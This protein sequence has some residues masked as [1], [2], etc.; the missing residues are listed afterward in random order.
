M[1]LG[2]LPASFCIQYPIDTMFA[3]VNG[4]PS[5][6]RIASDQAFSFSPVGV[7]FSAVACRVS[8]PESTDWL[9]VVEGAV[10]GVC[11]GVAVLC[12]GFC[13]ALWLGDGIFAVAKPSGLALAWSSELP[14]AEGTAARVAASR[15]LAEL[16]V[17]GVGTTPTATATPRPA[18]AA[19][20][21]APAARPPRRG[22]CWR[23]DACGRFNVSG[24]PGKRSKP[25]S[26]TDLP[27]GNGSAH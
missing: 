4:A 19:A 7:W 18:R 14:T 16:A 3:L 15:G 8:P 13:D 22:F 9:D 6:L 17:S 10:V 23:C 27:T 11:V 24:P 12:V 21:P 25:D 20:T 26:P 5:A 2:G 1:P